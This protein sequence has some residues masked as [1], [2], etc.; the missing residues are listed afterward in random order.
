M[1]EFT[2]RET[3]TN[4]QELIEVIERFK[5]AH[6]ELVEALDI[7]NLSNDWYQASLNALYGPQISWSNTTNDS[8]RRPS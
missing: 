7:F 4:D 8:V 1:T 6:P 3:L 2:E 5:Q